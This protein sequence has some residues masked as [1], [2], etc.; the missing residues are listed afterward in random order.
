M[1][2]DAMKTSSSVRLYLKNRPYVLAAI[3]E[4]IVNYSALSRSVKQA[5]GAKSQN[6]VKAAVIRYAMERG[7]RKEVIELRA[8][9]VI[10]E[11]RISLLDKVS[12][13]V[14]NKRLRIENEAEVKMDFYY[15]YLVRG[16]VE[17]HLTKEEKYS[18]VE[19]HKNC[20][21]ITIYSGNNI[22]STSGVVAFM[23][24]LLAEYGINIVELIS[25]YTETM[26]VVN[27]TDAVASYELLS[28]A[29]HQ[30]MH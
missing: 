24:S 5:I 6:A 14:S 18:V 27:S 30:A 11:N 22:E 21:M 16:G 28:G 15:I 29:M 8:L 9:S 23:A 25:C 13:I 4:G 1:T 12:V 7:A 26:L 2:F 3:D 19:Q 17:K 10:K 20:S